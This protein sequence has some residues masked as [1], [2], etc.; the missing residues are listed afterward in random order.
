MNWVIPFTA[1]DIKKSLLCLQPPEGKSLLLRKQAAQWHW[2]PVFSLGC[3]MT[4]SGDSHWK[5]CQV[6]AEINFPESLVSF[7]TIGQHCVFLCILRSVY[8]K[9]A[10]PHKARSYIYYIQL[11]LCKFFFFCLYLTSVFCLWPNLLLKSFWK[12]QANWKFQIDLSLQLAKTVSE[13]SFNVVSDPHRDCF[14]FYYYYFRLRN[15]L[16]FEK[17]EIKSRR[18]KSTQH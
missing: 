4:F 10:D 15:F 16:C 3:F 17:L 5:G 9:G 14:L 7:Y 18:A 13:N 2:H 6:N 12:S 8:I 1:T 11:L